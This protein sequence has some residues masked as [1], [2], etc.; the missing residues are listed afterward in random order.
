MNTRSPAVTTP[1]TTKKQQQQQKKTPRDGV[2]IFVLSAIL[3]PVF[4]SLLE[5]LRPAKTCF[6]PWKV[7]GI[8]DGSVDSWLGTSVAY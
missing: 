7:V 8:M 4:I 2:K 3:I 6:L 5:I 1:P